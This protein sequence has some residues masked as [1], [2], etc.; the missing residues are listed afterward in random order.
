[1]PSGNSIR[2]LAKYSH[3]TADAQRGREA[4]A[5]AQRENQ[6]LQQSGDADGAGHRQRGSRWSERANQQRS[7][8]GDQRQIEQQRRK[9]RQRE[10]VLRVQESHHHGDRTCKGE[11]GQHQPRVINR[12]LQ[13]R[14]PDKARRQRGDDERHGEAEDRRDHDQRQADGAEHASGERRGGNGALGI[15]HPQPGRHQRRI[16]CAFAQQS[17]GHIDQL[18]RHQEC[19]GHGAGAEQRR[20]HCVAGKSQQSRS[21]CSGRYGEDGTDHESIERVLGSRRLM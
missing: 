21:Q 9:R 11:I 5:T 19:I 15:A 12:E 13:R 14:M 20:H 3:D 17:P 10:A 2:R 6:Q 18:K 1:M 7:H 8:H 16:Q 4:G